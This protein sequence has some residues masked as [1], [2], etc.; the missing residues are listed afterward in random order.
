MK[1]IKGKMFGAEVLVI[2]LKCLALS[3]AALS[4]GQ[5]VEVMRCGKVGQVYHQETG[6]CHQPLTTGPCQE[7]MMVV[8]DTETLLARCV[9]RKCEDQDT[10][11]D[12]V[13]GQ[14]VEMYGREVRGVR[15][16]IWSFTV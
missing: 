1:D 15:N 3:L 12:E 16:I 4:P 8:L 11:W 9:E 7:G 10:L 2:L 13:S 5:E 6:A 14:C